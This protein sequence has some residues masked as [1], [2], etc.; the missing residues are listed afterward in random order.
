MDY[1]DINMKHAGDMVQSFIAITKS[2]TRLTQ[3]NASSLGLTMSQMGILNLVYTTPGI[4]IKELTERLGIPKS[5]ASV[6]TEELVNAELLERRI[7]TD[8]RREIN[9][10]ITQRGSQLSQ[11]SCENAPSYKAMNKALEE[12]EP[13]DI[14]LMLNLHNEILKVIKAYSI[15]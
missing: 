8:D 6:T 14:T 11:K 5:T 10:Y 2:L 4:T 15:K 1:N 9:L 7:S 3:Q 12:L 13:S